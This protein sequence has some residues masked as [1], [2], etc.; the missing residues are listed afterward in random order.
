M[1]VDDRNIVLEVSMIGNYWDLGDLLIKCAEISDA[2]AFFEHFKTSGEDFER[3]YEKLDF[4]PS[5]RGTEEWIGR[6]QAVGSGDKNI[7]M[8][9]DNTGGFVGYIEVWEADRRMGTFRYGIRIADGKMGKG[10]ATRALRRVLGFYFNELRYQKSDIYIYAFNKES[11]SFHKK[12]GFSE[13][14][15]LRRQYYSMG[16]YHDALCFG[17]TVEEFNEKHGNRQ[18]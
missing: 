11:I 2:G 1:R 10:Y 8:I 9:I 12:I 16:R 6:Y 7:F 18:I 17:M 13:E 4:P 14:G 3:K 15:R 5:I